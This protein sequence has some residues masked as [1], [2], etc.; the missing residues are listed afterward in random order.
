MLSARGGEDKIEKVIYNLVSNAINY[1]RN[2]KEITINIIDEGEFVNFEVIDKGIEIPEDQL[3]SIWDRYYK[4]GKSHKGAAVGS[5][6]GLSIVKSILLAHKAEFA[7]D[8]KLG[9]ASK[10]YFKLRKQANL[11]F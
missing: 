3:N 2:R 4:V 10:F 9:E 8:S 7:V 6:I 5:G 1:T 11:V